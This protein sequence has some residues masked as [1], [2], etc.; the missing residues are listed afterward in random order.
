MNLNIA[1]FLNDVLTLG[2]MLFSIAT[3]DTNTVDN[4]ALLGLV[5]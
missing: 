3:S 4:V 2:S 5:T 1:M